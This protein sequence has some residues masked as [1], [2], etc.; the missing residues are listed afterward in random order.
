MIAAAQ[1]MPVAN[2]V[3]GVEAVNKV[4]VVGKYKK[5]AKSISMARRALSES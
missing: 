1:R 4:V 2:S 5:H 3:N